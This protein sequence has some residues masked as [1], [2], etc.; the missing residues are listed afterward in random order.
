MCPKLSGDLYR[1][2]SL[3]HPSLHQMFL[4]SCGRQNEKRKIE[5]IN[6]LNNNIM[7]L[8]LQSSMCRETQDMFSL[9]GNSTGT[10]ETS[11]SSI[12]LSPLNYLNRTYIAI[13]TLIEHTQ[14]LYQQSIFNQSISL[15]TS[16]D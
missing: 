16:L 8:L 6:F 3:P 4:S 14:P 12:T 1:V 5:A 11:G 9:L 15:S 7:K 13:S 10:A 2:T